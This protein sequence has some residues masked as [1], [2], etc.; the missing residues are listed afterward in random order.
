MF[1]YKHTYIHTH[2]CKYVNAYI[3]SSIHPS[4]HICTCRHVNAHTDTDIHIYHMY[5]FT[6]DV[7][8]ENIREEVDDQSLSR[9]KQLLFSLKRCFFLFT[10]ILSLIYVYLYAYVCFYSYQGDDDELVREYVTKE[11]ELA[12]TERDRDA[13]ISDQIINGQYKSCCF[14]SCFNCTSC[15][16]IRKYV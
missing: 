11:S 2:I 3:H 5:T 12:R 9:Y 10:C 7:D 4:I 16:Y 14:G 6:G 1:T 13:Y 15:I 8:L